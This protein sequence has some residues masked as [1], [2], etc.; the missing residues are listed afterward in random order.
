MNK[1][2]PNT[3]QTLTDN[4][5]AKASLITQF[6]GDRRSVSE[7]E[8][9]KSSAT[10]ALSSQAI[11]MSALESRI[12]QLPDLD[13]ARVVEL[14]NRIVAGEYKVDSASIAEKMLALESMIDS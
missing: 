11:D 8:S 10:V 6:K 5:S 3:P 12:K 7:A 13:A 14:H 4:R 2:G 9:P 1:I